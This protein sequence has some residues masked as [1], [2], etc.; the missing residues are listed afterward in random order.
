MASSTHHDVLIIGAGSAGLSVA[1]RLAHQGVKSI[2]ILDPP[3]CTTTS[4]CGH[5]SAAAAHR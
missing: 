1:A 5:W 2:G 4:R 3:R